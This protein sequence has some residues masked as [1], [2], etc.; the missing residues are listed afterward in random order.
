ME[1]SFRQDEESLGRFRSSAKD[2]SE[3]PERTRNS[4][5]QKTVQPDFVKYRHIG[6][7]VKIFGNFRVFLSYLA[8]F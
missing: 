3:K 1:S 8:K 7:H 2:I 4:K 5:K 6:E